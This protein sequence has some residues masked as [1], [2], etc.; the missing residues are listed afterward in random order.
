MLSRLIKAFLPRNKRL[1]ISWLQSP[2]A[3]I[4]EPKKIKSVT[5]SIVFPSVCHEVMGL[6]VWTTALSNSVKLWA[7]PCRATQDRW[8]MVESSD[9]TW[10]RWHHPYGRKQRRTKELL[11]ESEGGEWN[12]WLKLPNQ[13]M[14]IMAFGPI[15][16][17]RWGNNGN[18]DRL[19]FLGLQ[20]HCRC[21]L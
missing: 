20:N 3:V 19:Y 8:V 5:V 2:S 15:R 17:N 4:L 10:S 9:K 1:L 21:W 12:I 16:A 7:M 13:K 18:R 14:C 6:D 11:D